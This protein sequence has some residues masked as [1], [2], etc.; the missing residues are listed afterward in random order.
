[1]NIREQPKRDNSHYVSSGDEDEEETYFEL[2]DIPEDSQVKYVAYKL[3][4]ATSSWWDNFQ[5]VDYEQTLYS[6][7]QNCRQYSRI[8]SEYTE[9]F[10]RLASRIQLSESY[11]QQVM[12]FNNGLCYDIQAIISLQTS[13]TLDEDVWMAL[14]ADLTISKGKSNSKFKNKPD[15]NQSSNQSGEKTQPLNSNKAEKNKSTYAS[16][17]SQ[18]TKK[19]INQYA[20]PVGEWYE[21]ESENKECFIRPEYVLDEEE[22]DLHEAYSYVVC[23]LMLTTPKKGEDT[24]RH[25]IF[26]TRCR[27]NQDVLNVIIDGGSTVGEVRVTK[28]CEVLISMGKYKDTILFDIVDMDAYHVLLGRPWQFDP[29][30]IHKGM[31][32]TYTFLKDG[33]KFTLYPFSSEDRPKATKEKASTILLFSREAF[34]VEV[35]H[36]QAV[37]AVVVKGDNKIMKN[38]SPKLHDLLSEFKNLMPEELP[39]G[40]PPLRD[41]QNQI[42]FGM[43]EELLRKGVIQESKSLCVVPALLVPKKDKTWHMLHGSRVFSKI[44]LRSG[45]HQLRFRP[46]DEWKTAFKIKEG[47]YEWLVMPFGLSNAPST[48]MRLRNQVLK[49]FIRKFLVVY[50]GDILIYSDTEDEH[51][52]HLREVLKVLQEHQLFVNLKKCSFMTHKLLFLGFVVSAD[53][54]ST[55]IAPI[56]EC[57]KKGRFHWGDDVAKSFSLIKQKLTSAPIL[58]LPNFQKPFELETDAS[59]IGVGAVLLQEGRPVAFFSEKLSEAR[60]KWTTYELEFYAIV[61][62]VKHWEQYLFQQEFVLQTNHEALKYFN[63]QKSISRMHARWMEYLQQFTFVIKH[64]A[65]TKNKVADALS[66]RATLLATMGTEVICFD[67]LKDLYASDDDFSE[68][69]KQNETSIP[70]YSIAAENFAEKIEAIQADVR[71]KHEAFNAKYKDDRD[72]HRMTKIYA[73]CDLVMVHLRKERFPVGTY[74]KLKKKKIGP[75]RILK[76]INDNAYVVDL[77]ED[78]AISN[79]FNVSDLVDYNP[80]DE[81]LYPNENSRSS[82][83]QVGENDE[84]D[85]L[86]LD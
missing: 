8:V 35:R 50:F 32:N 52:D 1:M 54:F 15:L 42:D 37:F 77:P 5:T 21:D 46:G 12:R 38:V 28:Q 29:G 51:L 57:L 72:K 85:N 10:M 39:D 3:R 2:M 13:W 20:W 11:A 65:G 25:N 43:V 33:K 60:R 69:W 16:T 14:K 40:L 76:R 9:E 6:L 44:D 47:L 86:E 24:Q 19:P 45:Y 36:A 78:M 18:A 7:Y 30:V 48:F 75:C 83:F 22:V 59:I 61:R 26:R 71:L 34:L 74:N 73:E 67:C 66:R 41:I 49:P 80:P 81:L 56:T 64:K 27:I 84:G 68:V 58:V 17:S 53:D 23:R 62:A 79:T 82:P 55:I 31:E 70:G 4:G 63:S